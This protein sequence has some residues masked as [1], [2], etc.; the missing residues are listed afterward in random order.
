ML[1]KNTAPLH[2]VRIR[3][4]NTCMIVLSSIVFIFL[5]ANTMLLSRQY[6]QFIVYTQEYIAC[7]GDASMLSAASDYLT[8][9]VR[10]YTQSMDMQYMEGYF[11]EINETKRRDSALED[12]QRFEPSAEILSSLE[13]ALQCSNG[14]TV[15]EIYAMKLISVANGYA[16]ETLP[17]EVRAVQLKLTDAEL[18]PQEMIERARAL[19][20]DSGY[21]DAKALI[22]S[23]LN[24]FVSSILAT[25]QAHQSASEAALGDSL[26]R[27]RLM[28]LLLFV[29]TIVTFAVITLLIVRPLTI[30]IKRIKENGM[31]EITGSYEFKYLAL[32]YNDI[33]EL[34][35]A[36][37][38][39]L[40]QRAEHDP[41][42]GVMNR[43]AFDS[44][45]LALRDHPVPLALM[46]L[47]VDV[48]KGINDTYGHE[49]GDDVLRQVARLLTHS[50]RPSD[51][52]IRLGGDEFAVIV[53]DIQRENQ[54][55]LDEKIS[56]INRVLSAPSDTLPAVTVSAGAAFSESGFTD[57]LF[58][59]A[60][61][62][63]YYVKNHGRCGL[64]I[65]GE[66]TESEN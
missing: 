63:L 54:H 26:I 52:V 64:H 65:A 14:L 61:Q 13:A 16:E 15:R 55:V 51:Y 60:D 50:F 38:A 10:L 12:L 31:L 25:M 46:I 19:V 4:F 56:T 5:I 18:P 6:H 11:T 28:I 2:G 34:N 30:H 47:D 49:A 45:K 48:F 44:L 59:L 35:A 29:T 3:T 17:E 58:S 1:E 53:M 32:T 41:L 20:F 23:H 22:R 57:D 21:Q 27:Q 9:Q 43:G 33:Y 39:M 7:E 8:E 37:Q 62:A 42:T 40:T 66:Q 36:T 24:H